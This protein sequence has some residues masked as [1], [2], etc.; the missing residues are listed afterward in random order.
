MTKKILLVLFILLMVAVSII[1][2]NFYKNIKEP[3]NKTSFEAIPINAA[4]IIKENNFNAIYNK[5]ASTN[6]I[7][8]ELVGN[9]T[10]AFTIKNQMHYLDS[11]L[12][13]PFAP[14]FKNSPILSSIHLSGAT[15]FD[16]IFYLPIVVDASEADI[17]NKIK[18]VTKKNTES[19]EYDGATI[20]TIST[21]NKDKISMVIY[22]NTLVFSYSTVLI[23]DVIRQLNSNNNL[24][25]DP[26]FSKV[27]NTSGQ[28]EDGNLFINTKYFSKIVT[29]Y[30]NKSTKT[31]LAGFE[32]YTGWTELDVNIKP[33]S[34]SFSGFSFNNDVDNYFIQLFKGQKPQ[35]MELLSIVPSN[36]S[37]IYYYGLSNSKEFFENRVKLLKSEQL[38]FNYQSYLDEQIKKYGIDLEATFL[39]NIGNELALVVTESQSDILLNNQYIIFQSNEIEKTKESLSAISQKIIS[40]IVVQPIEFNGYSINQLNIPNLF[41]NLLGKPFPDFEKNYYAIIDDYVVFG[42]SENALQTFITNY[43]TKKV[44][45]TNE[46]FKEFYDNLSSSSTIFI[47]NNIARST[48]LYKIYGAADFSPM[49][50][51]KIELFRKFEAVAFQ[52]TAEKNNLFYNTIFLKYNPVYKQ[53]TSSLWELE[54]D[55]TIS[56]T[57]QL[58]VNHITNSKEIIVQDDANTIYLISNT[59]KVIWSKQLSERVMSKFYQIDIF[60][61]NKLQLLFNTK[62][63]I[64]LIDRNG[65][66]VGSY[67]IKLP[68]DA[69]NGIS[70]LDYSNDKNYRLLIG[71]SNNMVYNYTVEGNKVDGWEYVSAESPAVSKIWHFALSGKD[72]L[73]VPLK[74]GKVKVIER[75]GKDRLKIENKLPFL[76]N[77]VYLKVGNNL[78]KTYLITSDTLGNIVKLFLN[79]KKEVITLENIPKNATFNFFDYNNDN[80]NDYIFMWNNTLKIIDADKKEI[81]NSEFQSA[82]TQTPLFFNMPNKSIKIGLVTSNQIYLINSE[83]KIEEDFP[84]LGS[85]PFTIADINNDKTTNLVV[86]DKRMIYTYVLK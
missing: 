44:L 8:E 86:A 13:G 80:S 55:S 3:I 54:L 52:V 72:Y 14:L 78:N 74:N 46:N 28:S 30:V 65:N 63:K 79:D 21:N 45:S 26:T 38:Y 77:E 68:S 17:I 60:K 5:I 43:T 69:S 64:Y 32:N 59:G 29:Q 51:E 6:I 37:F 39:Q 57:P 82:I 56:A 10:T 62:S 47:Y 53:E 11:I 76:S 20:Y 83:G 9:T 27:I 50:D 24:L 16:F 67:P 81:F 35:E 15:N 42:N 70:V 71:C 73:V 1:A 85:T 4:V 23:E 34:L 84:L 49:I 22:K 40:D 58:V 41:S 48:N 61:N 12:S 36:T 33:N 2:Y 66:N 19:R 31:Y 75:S 25:S 18:I 7:W